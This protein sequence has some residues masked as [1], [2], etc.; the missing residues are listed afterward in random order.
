MNPATVIALGNGILRFIDVFERS[1]KE[2]AGR[3]ID[4]EILA[5]RNDIR[6]A[7]VALANEPAPASA[8]TSAKKPAPDPADGKPDKK[9]A[10]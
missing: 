3:T 10:P 5:A 4:L 9:D 8:K 7:V 2:A 6:E 1:R